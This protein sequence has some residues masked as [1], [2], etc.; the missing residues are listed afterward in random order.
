MKVMD[1]KN[2]HIRVRCPEVG[3]SVVLLSS[4]AQCSVIRVSAS[5]GWQGDKADTSVGLLLSTWSAFVVR[6]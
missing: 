3:L 1:G 2:Y 5:S 6:R 4:M